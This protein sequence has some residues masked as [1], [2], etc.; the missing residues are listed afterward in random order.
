MGKASE[1]RVQCVFDVARKR[2]HGLKVME[3]MRL[4]LISLALC[5]VG[6]ICS[7]SDS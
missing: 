2:M 1:S 6:P 7:H 3:K 4:D 5:R